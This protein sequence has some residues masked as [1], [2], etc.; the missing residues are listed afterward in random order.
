MARP[1]EHEGAVQTPR[2]VAVIGAGYVGIPTAVLLAHFGHT[3]V[4]AERDEY[5]R[6]MLQKGLSPILEE[7]LEG[8]L[9][10]C[11]S[12][13]RLTIVEDAAIAVSDAEFVFLCVNTPMGIDGHADLSYVDAVCTQIHAALP[14]GAIVINKSTVPVGTSRRVADLLGRP[15]VPVV[16]NPEFL[17][18]GTAVRD[19]FAPDR[20]VVGGDNQEAAAAVGSLFALTGAPLVVT[21]APTAELIKYAANTF[22]TTKLSFINAMSQLCDALG[23]NAV[24]LV[25]GIG[26][27]P[28]IGFSFLNPGPGWGG[29][30]LPKDSHALLAIAGTVDE[31]IPLIAAAIETNDRQQRHIVSRIQ[32][33]A[34]G[35]LSGVRVGVLGLTFKANTGDRRDSPALVITSLLRSAGAEV[36]AYDPTVPSSETSD[37]LEGLVIVET[38]EEAARGAKVL[39]LLTEWAEFTTLDFGALGD[40]MEQRAFFDGRNIVNLDEARAHGFTAWGIGR[41]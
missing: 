37:D 22:L 21:D 30:C 26:Y 14:H 9:A 33:L 13:G 2:R 29:P 11:V 19:S 34:G 23:A 40:V 7:D 20:T 38:A 18:E 32:E 36:V 31:E 17:R 3:V 15:D 8:L 16:S 6:S 4:I 1:G 25:K 35:S 12:S 5:R 39:V 41:S 28:R 24:D 27:D 10:A